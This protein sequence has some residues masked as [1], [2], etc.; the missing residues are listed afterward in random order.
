MGRRYGVGLVIGVLVSAV[1][2]VTSLNAQ[3][4]ESK[5]KAK[6]T[7]TRS[8]RTAWG[9]PDIQGIWNFGTITPLQRP[10]KGEFAN[11][12]NLTPEEV[13]AI[14][15]QR[16]NLRLRR[17]PQE[18]RARRPI[19]TWHI[20]RNGGIAACRS[21]A[22]RSSPIRRTAACPVHP[23]RKRAVGA[24]RVVAWAVTAAATTHYRA[25]R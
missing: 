9:E 8:S 18:S 25:E 17:E 4:P 21:V 11:R 14:N 1:G 3:A 10:L 24:P 6:G 5:D 12:L 7:S 2:L 13:Q 15:E 19:A 22:R 20:T 23:G 16:P